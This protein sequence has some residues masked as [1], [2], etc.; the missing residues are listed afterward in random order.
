M[1]KL[2]F[3]WRIWML[4]PARRKFY[5][6]FWAWTPAVIVTRTRTARK[7]V[8]RCMTGFSFIFWDQEHKIE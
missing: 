6:W 8:V 1:V 3:P 5:G 2:P 4:D 7:S